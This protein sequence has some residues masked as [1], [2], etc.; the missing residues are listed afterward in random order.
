M[1]PPRVGIAVPAD[2]LLFFF[3]FFVLFGGV[4]PLAA[5][6][7]EDV[8][9]RGALEPARREELRSLFDRAAGE[10]I[11][12][13]LLLPRLEEGLAKG[14]PPGRLL[15]AIEREVAFLITARQILKEEAAALG[16]D[17]AS[18]ARTANLLAGGLPEAEVRALARMASA[19][20][21][22]YR[23]ATYLYVALVDWGLPGAAAA[24]LLEA[25]LGSQ[26]PGEEFGGIVEL[27]VAG[28]SARVSPERLAE[29]I[30]RALPRV[31]SLEDLKALVLY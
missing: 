8:L 24:E 5:D 2:I 14:V 30:R 23:A 21:R 9:R 22:E 12:P 17:E 3:L 26:L 29:R 27:F 15:G 28:R 20:P 10:G 16:G 11:P 31:R 4:G 6:E 18:W 13:Q 19:R 25:L 1:R 7:L